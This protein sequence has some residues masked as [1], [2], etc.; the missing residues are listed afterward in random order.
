VANEVT[1][2]IEKKILRIFN[3]MK[4][5]LISIRVMLKLRRA[6]YGVLLLVAVIVI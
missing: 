3:E 6:K 2:D 1:L 5:E 4:T